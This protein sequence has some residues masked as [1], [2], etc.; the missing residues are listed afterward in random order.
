[1]TTLRVAFVRGRERRGA[2]TLREHAPAAPTGSRPL[3][4]A[5]MLACAHEMQAMVNR[6]EVRDRTE[7][8]ERFGFARARISQLLDLLLLAPDIQEELLF[9]EVTAGRDPIHEH[10]L[11]Q[12]VRTPLWTEQRARWT[13]LQS[14]TARLDVGG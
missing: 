9:L 14:A 11:R 8:A 3:R 6:G 7:L 5:R 10:A 4:V 12:V 13:R 1:M 2:V